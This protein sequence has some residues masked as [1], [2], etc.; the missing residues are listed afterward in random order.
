MANYDKLDKAFGDC[1]FGVPGVPNTVGH[2]GD[3]S[4]WKLAFCARPV[5]RISGRGSGAARL[6][7][8][9]R[10]H[11]EARQLAGLVSIPHTANYAADVCH[12]RLAAPQSRFKWTWLSTRA[13]QS[14]GM[15][16]C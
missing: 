5:A 15:K 10:A 14:I 16:W 12:S 1:A 8:A 7:G 11:D 9:P 13:T 3:R 2:R 6:G 4:S